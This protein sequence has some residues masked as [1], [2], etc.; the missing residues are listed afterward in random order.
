[1]KINAAEFFIHAT[2]PVTVGKMNAIALSNPAAIN[3][4]EKS[5]GG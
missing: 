2:L 3:M 1:L 4:H 5:F